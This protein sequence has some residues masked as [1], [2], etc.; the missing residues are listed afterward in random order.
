MHGP[1]VFPPQPDGVWQVVYSGDAWNTAENEDRYRRSLYTFWRRTSPHPAMT[2]LDAGSR[3]TCA[4]RRIRT[5]T[6]LQA[7]VL[8]N[9]ETSIET[10]GGLA[11]RM[12][13]SA[14]SLDDAIATGFRLATARTPDT[15]ELGVLRDLHEHTLAGYRDAPE[16]ANALLRSARITAP[17]TIDAADLAARVVIANVLLNLD[18]FVTRG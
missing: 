3:E 8:L 13:E 15:D 4:V 7:L 2:T 14:T 12:S 16:S 17:D 6:P 18:E 9:D 10:A 5:N 1:P 11:L